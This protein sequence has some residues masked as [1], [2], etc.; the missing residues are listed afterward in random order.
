MSYTD[1]IVPLQPENL[2]NHKFQS[3]HAWLKTKR[4]WLA[5]LHPL[6]VKYTDNHRD[7]L[8]EKV[9]YQ[10]ER[11]M[12]LERDSWDCAKVA[13]NVPGLYYFSDKEGPITVTSPPTTGDRKSMEPCLVA[14]LIMVV[15]L[16]A[17]AGVARP[18]LS[19]VLATIRAVILGAICLGQRSRGLTPSQLA[20]LQKIPDDVRTAASM[21]NLDTSFISFACCPKCTCIYSPNPDSPDDPYPRTCTHQ[22]TDE[23]VCGEPLVKEKILRPLKKGGQPRSV[24]RAIRTYPYRSIHSWIADMFSRHA[25]EQMCTAC[26]EKPEDA[27]SWTDI[28]DSPGIRTFPGPDGILFSTPPSHR[29]H[30]VFCLFIDWFNPHGNKQAG[31]HHSVGAIYLALLNLPVHLRYRPENIF[32]AGIIPGPS[33]PSLHQ[34]NHLLRP[35]VDELLDL[36]HQGIHIKKTFLSPEFG[37]R[38]R[39]ALIPLVCDLPASRKAAGFASHSATQ[40]CSFCLLRK[41]DICNVDRGTWPGSRTWQEHVELARAWRDAPTNKVREEKFDAHGLRW[42]ELLRLPYWD[43]T[44]FTLLD[45]MHN[46]FLGELHHHC[47]TLWGMKTADGRSG[48]GIAPRNSSKVH[49]PAEQQ[50]CLNK[51]AAALRAPTISAK[52]VSAARK[53]YLATIVAFNSIP[54]TRSN[55]GKMD[56]AAKLVERVTS[57]GASSILMPPAL[58][59]PSSNFHLV[60]EDDEASDPENQF[61]RIFTG[62]VLQE[63]RKDIGSIYVPSWL[64]RPPANI[65]SAATGKLKADHWRTLCTVH[66]V[67]TLGRLWGGP[68]AS[69]DEKAALENFMHLVAAVDL[70]TRRNM[71]HERAMAFDGH[72]EAYLF[73]IRSLYDAQ[74]VPNHHLSLH[75]MDCLLLF[76]PTHGW[77][78][79]PFE[80]YNGM[81]QKLKTNHK[82]S[83]IP[84]TFMRGFYTG[85]KLRW[86]MESE[87]W[88]ADSEFQGMVAA[89]QAAFGH[90]THRPRFTN[91]LAESF[92]TESVTDPET[93]SRH[94]GSEETSL[95]PGLYEKLRSSINNSSQVHFASL[96]NNV[97]AGTSDDR[98]FLPD[99]VEFISRL[100]HLGVTY[101]TRRR[102]GL[103]NSF[104]LFRMP[105]SDSSAVVAGQI[106]SIFYHTRR[107]GGTVITEPFFLVDK[108]AQLSDSAQ[109]YDPYCKFPDGNTWLCY[110]RFEGE[111]QLLQ[112]P[113][114]VTHFAAL[115]YTP[116]GIDEPCIV[117][118][119]SMGNSRTR[120][121]DRSVYDSSRFEG[122]ESENSDTS[123][124]ENKSKRVRF[125]RSSTP[126][127]SSRTRTSPLPTSQ[128]ICLLF[129]LI[130]V[131]VSMAF[132]NINLTPSFAAAV[133][134]ARPLIE[135]T[136]FP[137]A[138]RSTAQIPPHIAEY[139]QQAISTALDN[140]LQRPDFALRTRGAIVIPSLTTSQKRL[141]CNDPENILD[142]GRDPGSCCFIA[143]NRGQVAIRLAEL[144]RP[145]HVVID[146]IIP[147][148][149]LLHHA[150]RQVILWGLVDGAVNKALFQSMSRFRAKHRSLGDGPP[151]SAS[152]LF[153]P[154]ANFTFD[155]HT[156]FPIQ[157]F[158]IHPD[159]VVSEMTSGLY[160][161]EIR[162]NWGGNTT[163]IC[164]VRLHGE[165]I[166]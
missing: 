4:S 18:Y 30:L 121:K 166:V 56:Y 139:V 126:P 95:P 123:G 74:L 156:A 76:G 161:L 55:P 20:L 94:P 97:D 96:S 92:G 111:Q 112:L 75:L 89:F 110:R 107:E 84:G 162:S 62:H 17:M 140:V 134:F 72:M 39:A 82:Q 103:R 81:L 48:P 33:E 25:I 19:F 150:P 73:G 118:L 10:L 163:G 69:E 36:W 42:S 133:D 23:P 91:V 80:R 59:Y 46:L 6:G 13:A 12:R 7:R 50:A 147:S 34:I 21:L 114:I 117:S 125:K 35:L 70:A 100:T 1:P 44:R 51:I 93:P 47:I 78:S 85:A 67:I 158:P 45:S 154:F 11:L 58:P 151:V 90:G 165:R 14:A 143:G 146:Y 52:S 9:D 22:E 159:I 65:G 157:T 54:I 63:I 128:T 29:V 138:R 144:I 53:D 148:H 66:M 137:A 160:I 132:F 26:W 153:L 87:T 131:P 155:I 41:K 104:I 32:L 106:D 99:A 101:A 60:E 5:E 88:P 61:G 38:I 49:S 149:P 142:E 27:D 145:T 152:F 102:R 8:I 136:S 129:L 2:N 164:R 15:I 77:W 130:I 98:P 109:S 68:S 141:S 108:F 116:T 124:V 64:E 79:F 113:D 83:D 127:R 16:H 122:D 31:R 43:P 119:S 71:S 28:M 3:F 120:K 24:F 135:A 115:E 37:C 57:R 86:L 40:F 105:D